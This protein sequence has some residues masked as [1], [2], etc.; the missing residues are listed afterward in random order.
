MPNSLSRQL[1]L[2]FMDWI[3]LVLMIFYNGLDIERFVFVDYGAHDNDARWSFGSAVVAS[4]TMMGACC[5]LSSV[6]RLEEN[7]R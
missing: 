3:P 2:S 6:D 7:K 5:L 4:T 1:G